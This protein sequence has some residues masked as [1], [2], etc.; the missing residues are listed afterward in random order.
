MI[1]ETEN[2][3]RSK[4][5]EETLKNLRKIKVFKRHWNHKFEANSL[6][7]FAAFVVVV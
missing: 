1:F 7:V 3:L 4:L 5:T 2:G 6:V